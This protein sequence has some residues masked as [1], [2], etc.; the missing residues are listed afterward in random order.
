MLI[1]RDVDLQSNSQRS[2]SL[3]YR[4]SP[5][6]DVEHFKSMKGL[7]HLAKL[8]VED[9]EIMSATRKEL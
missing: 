2:E 7:E 8:S 1:V 3:L 4:E 9:R 6:V 5:D